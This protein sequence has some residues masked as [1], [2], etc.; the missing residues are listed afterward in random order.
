M[1]Q[2]F[3]LDHTPFVVPPG[4]MIRFEDY[5]PNFTARIEALKLELPQVSSK[6]QEALREIKQKLEQE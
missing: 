1:D 5:D 3:R 4:K 6:Q 2:K